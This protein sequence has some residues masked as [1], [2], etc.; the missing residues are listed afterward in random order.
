M[1]RLPRSSEGFLEGVSKELVKEGVN[2][3]RLAKRDGKVQVGFV[4]EKGT[5][6]F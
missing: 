2:V 3:V 5:K 4:K 6:S 1:L